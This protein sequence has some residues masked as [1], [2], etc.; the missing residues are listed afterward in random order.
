LPLAFRPQ[1]GYFQNGNNHTRKPA[2]LFSRLA[3][4]TNWFP[5]RFAGFSKTFSA[6]SPPAKLQPAV[7]ENAFNPRRPHPT[8]SKKEKVRANFAPDA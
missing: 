3:A 6:S 5:E 8:V 2:S 4:L 7:A 1:S